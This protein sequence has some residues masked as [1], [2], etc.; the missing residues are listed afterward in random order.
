VRCAARNVLP[1]PRMATAAAIMPSVDGACPYTLQD[2]VL[3]STVCI[4]WCPIPAPCRPGVQQ[5]ATVSEGG[6][7]F[8]AIQ[9]DLL[10]APACSPRG[11]TV[12]GGSEERSPWMEGA[13]W[14]HPGAAREHME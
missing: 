4:H 14:L 8:G 6:Q 5:P 2:A 12:A 1:V 10:L 7:A 13:W 9:S 11:G 3:C